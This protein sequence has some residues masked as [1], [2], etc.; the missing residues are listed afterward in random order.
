MDNEYRRV[1]IDNEP[2]FLLS[3]CTPTYN[4]AELFQKSLEILLPQVSKFRDKVSI[5]IFDNASTD[6]TEAMI[7]TLSAKYDV[8]VDYFRQPEN[9]GLERNYAKATSMSDGRYTFIMCDDD[10]FAP[11]FIKTIIEYIDVEEEFSL[12]HFNWMHGDE[13]YRTLYVQNK[14]YEKDVYMSVDDFFRYA[15]ASPNFSS[16]VI[17]NTSAWNLGLPDFD[18]YDGNG[19]WGFAR[20][21]KG[22]CVHN[23]R[24]VYH[25]F[26]LCI[27]RNSTR[28]F[29]AMIPYYFWVDMSKIFQEGDKYIPGI[30]AEY[31][32][33]I[34]Y[35]PMEYLGNIQ[36][37]TPFYREHRDEMKEFLSEEQLNLYDYVI[38][39]RNPR[40]A[41]KKWMFRRKVVR[42][43]K[44]CIKEIIL[45][46]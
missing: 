28:S 39:A 37:D 32:S 35:F 7:R 24:C 22:A 19:Y 9:V 2:K 1:M 21:L 29:E 6:G 41:Y 43:L 23:K 20:L 14:E 42:K 11:N 44:K 12:I 5:H 45:H 31:A 38:N 33:H 18:E 26:P 30:Y 8:A 16:S 25:H 36:Y 27:Q 15:L 17:I 13:N 3:I 4:R 40:T 46:N 10:L 34:P